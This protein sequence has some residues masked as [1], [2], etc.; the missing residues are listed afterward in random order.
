MPF[1][2]VRSTVLNTATSQEST[3]D[4]TL[5]RLV[6]VN[7]C[8]VYDLC[9]FCR[10]IAH[11]KRPMGFYDSGPKTDMMGNLISFDGKSVVILYTAC[12]TCFFTAYCIYFYTSTY[13]VS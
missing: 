12:R 11:Y 10:L 9:F 3:S 13:T 2:P 7:D 1:P 5:L 8:T 4:S 6:V